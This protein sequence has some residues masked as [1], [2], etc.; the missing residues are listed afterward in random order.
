[1]IRP[2]AARPVSKNS[3]PFAYS[4][5][6]LV[7][8]DMGNSP[9]TQYPVLNT[10]GRAGRIR[11]IAV[12]RRNLPICGSFL[13]ARRFVLVRTPAALPEYVRTDV[14]PEYVDTEY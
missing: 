3:S 14:R 7:M 2:P 1:M 13:P 10:E 5:L 9:S 4:S 6:G 8:S 12:R 11:S